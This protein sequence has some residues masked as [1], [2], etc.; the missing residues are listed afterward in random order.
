MLYVVKRDGRE[1]SFNSVKIATAIRKA[2]DEIGERLKEVELLDIVKKVIN[3]IE[4]T[5]NE[6]IT[7]EEIQNLV[8]KS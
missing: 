1:V 4:E 7:V 8:E 6:K 2:G 3:Y 5:G